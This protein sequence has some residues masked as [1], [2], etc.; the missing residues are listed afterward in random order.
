MADD[1]FGNMANSVNMLLQRRAQRKQ[2]EQK[3]R[4]FENQAKNLRMNLA[5]IAYQRG[6]EEMGEKPDPTGFLPTAPEFYK[7]GTVINGKSMAGK[8]IPPST[9]PK[10][11]PVADPRF[12]FVANSGLDPEK[13]IEL[14]RQLYKEPLAQKKF[15]YEYKGLPGKGGSGKQPLGPKEAW[16]QTRTSYQKNFDDAKTPEAME[17]WRGRL[18]FTEKV[19][20]EQGWLKPEEVIYSNELKQKYKQKNEDDPLG[21]KTK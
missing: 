13:Q 20:L 19:G 18:A 6:M 3:M 4:D 14:M 2:Q 17:S 16:A 9:Q 1:V 21:I 5:G 12:Q 8:M 15:V 7:P 11:N 10:Y